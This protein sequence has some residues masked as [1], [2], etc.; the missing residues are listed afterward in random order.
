MPR[1]I[2]LEVCSFSIQSC[3]IAEKAGAARVELC[4]NPTDGGTTPCYGAIVRARERI[5]IQL[6]PI[7]RPRGGHYCYDEDEFAAMLKDI[8]MCREIGCNGISAGVQKHNGEIDADRLKRIVECAQPLGVTCNRA[9]DGTPDPF[10]ALEEIIACGCERVLTSGQ[11]SGAPGAIPVLA[12][13]VRQA[14]QRLVVMPGAGVRSTNIEQLVRETRAAE[15]HSS[16]RMAVPN[17]LTHQNPQVLDLGTVYVA[18]E[19]EL[20]QILSLGNH[21]AVELGE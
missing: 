16:A 14:G 3:L 7:I 11:A 10:K 15:Y 20:R 4:A 1:R 19:E 17:D 5:S 13:L 21:A 12:R 8:R 18:S 2:L 9:F 6:Y